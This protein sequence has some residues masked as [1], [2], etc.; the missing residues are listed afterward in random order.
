MKVLFA[1]SSESISD[2]IIKKYQRE[3]KEILSYKNVYYFN[4]I[5]KE[6]QKDKTYDR[7][8]ISEDLEPFSNNNYEAIDKFIFEKLDNI[9]D[10]AQ[11]IDG[12]ETSII[13]ICTDRHTKGSSF[14]VKL[15]GIG[16]YNALLGNDRSM[17]QV[18]RLINKPRVKKEAKSYYKIDAD[19]VNYS[20]KSE[21]EVSEL[22][23]QNILTHFK[24]LGKNTDKF[25]DSFN[26]I[27]S[28][29]T[30]EQLKIIINCLP[31]NVKAVLEEDC[32]K[33]QEIMSVN[34][35]MQRV[36]KES[37]KTKE[38]QKQTGIKIDIIENKMNQAKMSG[39]IVI[40]AS[41]RTSK[42]KGP[43]PVRPMGNDIE[44]KSENKDAS[45]IKKVVKRVEEPK[46]IESTRPVRPQGNTAKSEARRENI[47][48]KQQPDSLKKAKSSSLDDIVAGVNITNE[49]RKDTTPKMRVS[50]EENE[51]IA[52]SMEEKKKGRGRPR[53]EPSAD[54][55]VKPKGKRGRPKKQLEEVEENDEVILPGMNNDFE[56]EVMLPGM[57]NFDDEI[58]PGLDDFEDADN[59]DDGMLPGL[60]DFE[61]AD[62][63]DDGM[64]PGLD[65]FEDAD[66]ED[67][68]ML[69]GLDD[70]EDADDED[71]G[72]LPG[73]DDFE[74]VDDEDDGMLPGMDDFEDADDEDDGMLP[75]M[76]DFEDVDD[77][78]DGMLPGLDDF[79]DADDED[80][81]M[82]PGMDDFEDVDDEDDG[83][84]P[85]L[86]DFED[87]DD[88]DDGMLPGMDDFEEVDDE[89][90]G[91]LP[92]MDD[93]EE[94]DDEDEILPEMDDFEEIDDEDDGMLPGMDDFEEVDDED[95][96]LPEMDDFEDVDDEDE[97]L[98][99]M[100]DFE[101]IEDEDYTDEVDLPGLDELDE[102]DDFS[103]DD[104]DFEEVEEDELL[105]NIEVD[106][107]L[108]DG[109]LTDFDEDT[110]DVV[111]ESQS[112]A[113]QSQEIES[114]KP[115]VDYSMSNLNS[116]L[117]KDKKIVTFLGTTKNGTS[118]LVNNLAALFSSCGISTAILDMTKNKN[119][120]YIY[121]NNEEELRNIAYN[122]I[123]KLQKGF[124]EGIKV[125]KNLSVY[126]ALP[127]DGK[128]YTDAEPILSTL[129]QNHSLILID[130]DF[131]T[132]PS[133]FASCQEIYLVQSMDILT[134]Q[135]LTAFLRDLKAK[136]VLESEKVRVVIN[137]EIKVRSLS[138]KAII[139]GMSFYNDPSMSFMTE[140][141]NKDM[142]KA[143]SIPFEDNAYSKYLDSMV[144][145]NVSLNGYS[146]A[147]LNKLKN[148]GDMV[149]PLVSKSNY[150]KVAP[151]GGQN[152]G[153]NA[154]SKN[155]NNTLN[156][157]KNKY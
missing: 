35:M 27:A 119:S 148:L 69:P 4:A 121:T 76:D 13:L 70:F 91:M 43:A 2:A 9:S 102:L 147:F 11:D 110:D 101:E 156:Q 155:M 48:N 143:C 134:I 145:C 34:G 37:M 55:Q 92:G 3:Y 83:M 32:P 109:L 51:E 79:E 47:V 87:V 16:I 74:D 144:N 135:P 136:G 1:V 116:L 15:F 142:V 103:N 100:D 8:V 44:I 68:G 127:N 97:M 64:L 26:S 96:I 125:N 115:Q 104:E 89:D 152:Y 38:A 118:F 62:D 131:D 22:E 138:E 46:Q 18:C 120:Y 42:N 107:D 77:E 122:S 81:G 146:K 49:D 88:E 93:F 113:S 139:G 63:E 67:D 141:F 137:K 117:T 112:Y 20:N 58:L 31:I 7:I 128:D 66:D 71:D 85:G 108:D 39:P 86:D 90:D 149:Y 82:L 133:Y 157:M 130:C 61:D 78:D 50:K 126:T 65:D 41:V 40:P 5:L 153:K 98:P 19:D 123:S 56:E 29:Y 114:I 30:D 36:N 154:F 124:A 75:G 54:A 105:P 12:N 106:D 111:S 72:M 53:K 99:E 59:E 57:D 73:L 84:L 25:A 151:Q 23:I 28:Q 21:K 95:E 6:I 17:E 150:G 129:V 94:V 45:K 132:D 14:L 60:D 80:D 24:K 33:Y 52:V 10:E 140:L